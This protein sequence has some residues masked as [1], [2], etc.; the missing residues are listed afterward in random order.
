MD[1]FK[2]QYALFRGWEGE[3]EG[4]GGTIIME[5]TFIICLKKIPE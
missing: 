2:Y 3:G 4:K 1:N 5:S